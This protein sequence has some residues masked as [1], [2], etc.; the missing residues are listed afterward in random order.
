MLL[1]GTHTEVHVN[2]SKIVAAGRLPKGGFFVETVNCVE[3]EAHYEVD[4]ETYGRVIEYLDR[5][6]I[7]IMLTPALVQEPEVFPV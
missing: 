7:Q 2:P 5:D 3:D 4:E 1:T 6:E